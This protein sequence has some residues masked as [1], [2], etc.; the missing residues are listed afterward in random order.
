[1][2]RADLAR[3]RYACPLPGTCNRGPGKGMRGLAGA[4]GLSKGFR[5]RERPRRWPNPAGV[6]LVGTS[7]VLESSVGPR[8]GDA[9]ACLRS[10]PTGATRHRRPQTELV[11]RCQ[12]PC[13]H[14]GNERTSDEGAVGVAAN[15]GDSSSWWSAWPWPSPQEVRAGSPADFRG[16]RT[17]V[18]WGPISPEGRRWCWTATVRNW[19]TCTRWRPEW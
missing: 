18:S 15:G 7:L 16:V 2:Y 19:P 6:D 5:P 17:R 9:I 13:R 11:Q 12:P 10:P 1:M 4:R 3:V 14:P 8:E